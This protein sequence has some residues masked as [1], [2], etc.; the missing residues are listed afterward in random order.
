VW[1][2]VVGG[3]GVMQ[4]WGGGLG[5]G[6]AGALA[7]RLGGFIEVHSALGEG[8][9]FRLILPIEWTSGDENA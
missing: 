5:L 8:S 1:S 2:S 4:E 9:T 6:P 7:Y 3:S